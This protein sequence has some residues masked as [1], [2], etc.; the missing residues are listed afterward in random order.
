[1]SNIAKNWINGEWVDS[2]EHKDSINPANYSVIGQYADA[3]EA[4]AATAIAAAKD[5]FRNTDWKDNRSLRAR[6][7]HEL[8]DAFENIH[9][10]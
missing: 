1:M 4:D 3:T 2:A 7:L 8:A 9:L 10:S 6:V 5:A